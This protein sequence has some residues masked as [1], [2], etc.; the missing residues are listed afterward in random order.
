[1]T[2]LEGQKPR[3]QS[4]ARVVD[5]LRLVAEADADG[6]SATDLS[7]RLEIPR[8]V[9]YHLAHTLAARQM[10]RKIGR[11]TYVLGVG[12][13]PLVQGFN[14]QM[15]A[16]Y[17]AAYCRQAA[18]ETGE[19]AYV[20]GWVNE[21]IVILATARSLATVQA[22]EVPIGTTGDAHARASG[23]LLLAMTPYADVQRYVA[24]HP[25][26]RRTEHTSTSEVELKAALDE[27]RKDWVSTDLEEYAP[28]LSCMA[29]PI[30][31]AP[32]QFVLSISVPTY[33]FQV[34]RSR[35]AEILKR[36]ARSSC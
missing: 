12:V 36:I 23:K 17:L 16:D 6:I 7:D 29:V 24:K 22:A 18:Q 14:R 2:I 35:Y 26:N 15:S 31:S 27:I 34:N 3:V 10:L 19:A 8:Q 32:S 25:L 13:V 28:G 30:P 11:G 33:R 1:V 9:V 21:E 20:C 5:I 4:A